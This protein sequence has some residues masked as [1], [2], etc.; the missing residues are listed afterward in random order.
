MSLEINLQT[1][2]EGSYSLALNG[3]ID[4]ESAPYLKKHNRA[5]MELNPKRLL[6]DMRGVDYISS[7][8]IGAL[9]EL[10]EQIVEQGGVI[11]YFG[12]QPQ[13]K[14]VLETVKAIPLDGVFETEE[15]ADEFLRYLQDMG[16]KLP[17]KN[18][19]QIE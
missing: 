10:K 7:A 8:G 3:P 18:T 12:I 5:L 14:S 17:P 6:L 11:S 9:F 4:S 1:K 16:K 19:D 15:E 2:H 13:V